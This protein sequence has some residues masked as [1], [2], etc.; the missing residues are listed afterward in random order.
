MELLK[1][2]SANEIVAQ[3]ISFLIL[4][5][6]LR[7]FAW[8]KLL[9]L[10]DERK[11]RIASEF[12]SIED[13]KRDVQG[14]KAEYETRLLK[15]EESAKARIQEAVVEAEKIVHEIKKNANLEA[16]KII[17]DSRKNILYETARAKEK[18]RD[19]IIDLI[20]SATEQVVSGKIK[21]EDD[22]KLIAEFLERV[23]KA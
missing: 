22:K 3:V 6:M 16:Q 4:L 23:D 1:L 10:L 18:L 12:R 19:E 9:K 15:I 2:L 14:L 8:K 5:F 21:S 17:D 20:V 7:A 13:T 11:E